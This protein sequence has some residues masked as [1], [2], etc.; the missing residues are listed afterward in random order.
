VRDKLQRGV[1]LPA[2]PIGVRRG[3]RLVPRVSSEHRTTGAQLA[4]RARVDVVRVRTTPP[5]LRPHDE[6]FQG[7]AR[8]AAVGAVGARDA[9]RVPVFVRLLRAR[10][11]NGLPDERAAVDRGLEVVPDADV[12]RLL[13]GG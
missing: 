6:A 5:V 3:V 9:G 8:V 2:G 1:V 11:P 4:H 13:Y 7:A 10:D 12:G